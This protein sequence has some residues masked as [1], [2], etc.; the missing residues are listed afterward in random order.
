M[1]LLCLSASGGPLIAKVKIRVIDNESSELFQDSPPHHHLC[2][3]FYLALFVQVDRWHNIRLCSQSF[4][5]TALIQA[6]PSNINSITLA[7]WPHRSQRKTC[8]PPRFASERNGLPR[9]SRSQHDASSI[10]Q[11][12]ELHEHTTFRQHNPIQHT[13]A[14]EAS[15][16]RRDTRERARGQEP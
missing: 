8:R 11:H 5:H 4:G 10:D 3:G 6:L 2:E 9:E 14:L 12:H 15:T 13:L 7:E 16:E 1:L